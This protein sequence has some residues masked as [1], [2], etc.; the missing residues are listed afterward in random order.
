MGLTLTQTGSDSSGMEASSGCLATDFGCAGPLTMVAM[1]LAVALGAVL[2]CLD[3]TF[4]LEIGCLG[5]AGCCC[6]TIGADRLAC[7]A[8]VAGVAELRCGVC[9]CGCCC[10]GWDLVFV[11]PVLT[12]GRNT[13]AGSMTL[14]EAP[15]VTGD[16]GPTDEA[17]AAAGL[18]RTTE[19]PPVA[20]GNLPVPLVMPVGVG[21]STTV[22]FFV[23]L[24]PL[25]VVATIGCG[26]TLCCGCSGFEPSGARTAVMGSRTGVLASPVGPLLALRCC[27]CCCCSRTAACGAGDDLLAGDALRMI[28]GAPT[29]ATPAAVAAL[30][31][32]DD[33]VVVGGCTLIVERLGDIWRSSLRLAARG[34]STTGG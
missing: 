1:V 19:T 2:C 3:T 7:T 16:D 23:R 24:P 6:C 10:C 34:D 14:F 28:T 4:S 8:A 30:D 15:A 22:V 5:V 20:A 21:G 31:E 12:I 18:Q 27:C 13:A 9:G 32:S 33:D 17:T 26:I 25:L 11:Y 29:P